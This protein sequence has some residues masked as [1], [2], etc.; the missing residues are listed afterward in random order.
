MLEKPNLSLLTHLQ[1]EIRLED[2]IMFKIFRGSFPIYYEIMSILNQKPIKPTLD[3][4]QKELLKFEKKKSKQTVQKY[5]NL[6]EQFELIKKKSTGS[7]RFDTTYEIPELGG[8]GKEYFGI[9]KKSNLY[10]KW[11]ENPQI[12]KITFK[13]FI[14]IILCYIYTSEFHEEFREEDLTRDLFFKDKY[15]IHQLFLYFTKFG[16]IQKSE[17]KSKHYKI[18]SLLTQFISF[19]CDLKQKIIPKLIQNINFDVDKTF[20]IPTSLIWIN[21]E[22]FFSLSSLFILNILKSN[23]KPLDLMDL[24]NLL[25]IPREE[26]ANIMQLLDTSN[27]IVITSEKR[28]RN[29]YQINQKG[30]DLDSLIRGFQSTTNKYKGRFWSKDYDSK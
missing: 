23:I 27:L 10:D 5:I 9:L 8:I 14:F 4:I 3:Y 18:T 11:K 7:R 26:M 17:P 2:I 19:F 30:K 16:F 21:F 13:K 22:D 15:H 25:K 29:K 12:F 28:N 1:K 20:T 24:Q 6:M